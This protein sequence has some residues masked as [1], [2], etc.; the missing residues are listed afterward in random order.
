MIV[1]ERVKL[2]KDQQE[3]LHEAGCK[4][5]RQSLV[6]G[7]P[8]FDVHLPAESYLVDARAGWLAAVVR[9]ASK[10][11]EGWADYPHKLTWKPASETIPAKVL[12]FTPVE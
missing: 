1:I 2:R 9:K 8:L 12:S 4:V 6:D 11:D 10:I 7:D 5:I 3:R